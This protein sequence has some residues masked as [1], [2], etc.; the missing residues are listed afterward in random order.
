MFPKG[1]EPG[2][3]MT[4][5]FVKSPKPPM[6]SYLQ[7]GAGSQQSMSPSTPQNPMPPVPEMAPQMDERNMLMQMMARNRPIGM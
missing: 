5:T 6:P 4:M 7:P 2:D 3:K 1:L